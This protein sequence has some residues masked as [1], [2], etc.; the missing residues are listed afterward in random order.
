MASKILLIAAALAALGSTAAIPEIAPRQY[1]APL[2]V[3]NFTSVGGCD[4][5]HG[6]TKLELFSLAAGVESECVTLDQATFGVVRSA[7][8]LN[9]EYPGCQGRLIFQ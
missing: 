8:I 6:T 7:K 5:T 1:P 4:S 9:Y 3:A 2:F